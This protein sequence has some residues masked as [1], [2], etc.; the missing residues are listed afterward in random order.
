MTTHIL[1][2]IE[3]TIFKG[4]FVDS[5]LE[6]YIDEL[7][8]LRHPSSIEREFSEAIKDIELR[9]GT[10]HPRTKQSISFKIDEIWNQYP[11]GERELYTRG[12]TTQIENGV[13]VAK[14]LTEL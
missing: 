13:R 11:K 5:N 2:T 14:T 9:K 8:K 12:T 4:G 3:S 1:N 10:I 7:S 6:K